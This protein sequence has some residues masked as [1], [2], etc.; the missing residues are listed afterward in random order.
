MTRMNAT[1]ADEAGRV[2]A[3]GE[4]RFDVRDLVGFV[5][6][7]LP[8]AKKGR[9][10]LDTRRRSIERLALSGPLETGTRGRGVR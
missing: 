3:S 4:M 5:A 8:V 6:S 1:I 7:W 10:H 2:V 9:H